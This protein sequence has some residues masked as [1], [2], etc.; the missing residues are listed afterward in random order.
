[1]SA[2]SPE[3]SREITRSEALSKAKTIKLDNT[4]SLD[5]FANEDNKAAIAL[6]KQAEDFGDQRR[7]RQMDSDPYIKEAFEMAD[8]LEAILYEQIE[9][10]EWLGPDVSTS[11][12]SKYDD[13]QNGM[14]MIVRFE[15]ADGKPI[16][17][18]LDITFANDLQKK[19]DI[20]RHSLISGK[21][22]PAKYYH[23]EATGK[24]G[25]LEK[26][27]N[28]VIKV[29]RRYLDELSDQWLTNK[30]KLSKNPVQIMILMEIVEQLRSYE[31]Y[32]YY[33]HKDKAPENLKNALDYFEKL[34]EEKK[35]DFPP[36]T[37]AE[38]RDDDGYTDLMS[39]LKEIDRLRH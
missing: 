6:D 5:D 13:Y 3:L 33:I 35:A 36:G 26:V 34:L 31:D 29:G 21:L 38:L 20:R 39:Q 7:Q 25:S 32:A 8:I 2:A 27:P 37:M 15:G 19:I 10:S 23:S 30:K 11:L 16:F 18:A 22:A 9:L 14:D 17:I 4:P 24:N 12:T 28:L 1:M